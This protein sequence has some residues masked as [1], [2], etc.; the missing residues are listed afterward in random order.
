MVL[1]KFRDTGSMLCISSINKL[2]WKYETTRLRTEDLGCQPWIP[3]LSAIG[4]VGNFIIYINH[5]I[6][7]K[8]GILL[9]IY[10]C[11]DLYQLQARRGAGPLDKP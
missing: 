9:N 11:T 2:G 7:I 8:S 4:T 1:Y 5:Q 6:V 3:L 10:S